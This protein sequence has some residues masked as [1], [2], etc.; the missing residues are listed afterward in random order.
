M[1]QVGEPN[2]KE[3]KHPDNPH[4]LLTTLTGDCLSQEIDKATELP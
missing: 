1:K 3:R 4:Y 2:L